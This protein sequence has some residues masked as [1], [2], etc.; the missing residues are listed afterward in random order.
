MEGCDRACSTFVEFRN[1]FTA[2]FGSVIC[3]DVQQRQLGRVFNLVD[4]EELQEF[5][6]FP[7]MQEKCGEVSTK[8]VLKVAEILSREDTR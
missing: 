6:D 4:D 1:W 5:R 8:A 3:Q 7:G 2:E